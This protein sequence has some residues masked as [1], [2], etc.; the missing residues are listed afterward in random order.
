MYR[1][2]I[3]LA[4][5]PHNVATKTLSYLFARNLKQ[6]AQL[7]EAHVLVDPRGSH[8]VVL[9]YRSLLQDAEKENRVMRKGRGKNNVVEEEVPSKHS[10]KN[11][12]EYVD[13]IDMQATR[14]THKKKIATPAA[15][16]TKKISGEDGR[17]PSLDFVRTIN[18]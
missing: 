1:H 4:P 9:H 2:D 12:S 13:P 5:S 8:H 15:S 3:V 7:L 17:W 6:R 16:K 10:R 11:G 18:S 14:P